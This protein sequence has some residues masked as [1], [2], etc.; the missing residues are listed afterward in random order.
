MAHIDLDESGFL[1]AKQRYFRLIKTTLR[2]VSV[3]VNT[4]GSFFEFKS[5]SLICYLCIQI[6]EMQ[7]TFNHT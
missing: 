4:S 1:S 7:V 5:C 6:T 3:P 2:N